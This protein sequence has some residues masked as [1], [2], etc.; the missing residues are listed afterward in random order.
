MRQ[1]ILLFIGLWSCA[2]MAAQGYQFQLKG[3]SE[4]DQE[5]LVAEVVSFH[6]F[7][8]GS[9]SVQ[10]YLNDVDTLA[11]RL[12]QRLINAGISPNQVL[13][14]KKPAQNTSSAVALASIVINTQKNDVLCQ[15]RKSTYQ[16]DSY[17][18]IGCAV[19]NN[20]NMSLRQ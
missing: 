12:R 3:R 16:Y 13:L 5:I 10:W 9:L 1:W 14:Q 20:L 8:G 6:Q 2:G 18:D 7:L 4:I 17:P 19:Q 15:S 11:E